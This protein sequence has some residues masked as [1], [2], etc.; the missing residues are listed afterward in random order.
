[1]KFF[2]FFVIG[3]VI[4]AIMFGTIAVLTFESTIE[5]V[6]PD[7]IIEHKKQPAL[8]VRA[9]PSFSSVFQSSNPLLGDAEVL[10]ITVDSKDDIIICG[11]YQNNATFGTI[12]VYNPPDSDEEYH[13]RGFIAKVSKIGNWQWVVTV[14][15]SQYSRVTDIVAG[16]GD[17]L[18]VTGYYEGSVVFDA[19]FTYADDGNM[20]GF[21]GKINKNGV[22]QWI[23]RT[24]HPTSPPTHGAQFNTIAIDS[25]GNLYVGGNYYKEVTIGINTYTSSTPRGRALIGKLNPSGVWLLSAVD[26]GTFQNTAYPSSIIMGIAIDS[27]FNVYIAGWYVAGTSIFGATVLPWTLPMNEQLFVAKAD[28]TFVW[29]WAFSSIGPGRV[30]A[31][32]LDITITSADEVYVAG[33]FAGTVTL[34]GSTASSTSTGPAKKSNGFLAKYTSA[35]VPVWITWMLGELVYPNAIVTDGTDVYV[36]GQLTNTANFDSTPLTSSA[37]QQSFIGYV[38]SAGVW[39][40]VVTET[41]ASSISK[42]VA[43][44]MFATSTTRLYVTGVVF[45]DNIDFGSNTI[46][47]QIDTGQVYTMLISH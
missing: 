32:G 47:S 34:A 42:S 19:T 11:Y 27:S 35:G 3:I 22:W 15:A 8:S 33:S 10:G 39:Q 9:P 1:M 23:T 7:N 26:T 4:F 46:T 21:V 18:Y 37:S 44:A 5:S 2:R 20:P 25:I 28:A 38:S 17:N 31:F 14:P 24:V 29:Q 40:W 12:N 30:G 43:R 6:E 16:A 41:P 45:N 13:D 36:C